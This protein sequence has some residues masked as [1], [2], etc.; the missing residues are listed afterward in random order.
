MDRPVEA[1]IHAAEF[2]TYWLHY[3]QRIP[4]MT[5]YKNAC[6]GMHFKTKFWVVNEDDFSFEVWE[7]CFYDAV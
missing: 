1:K 6:Y 5:A 7:W 3:S 2:Y 4:W